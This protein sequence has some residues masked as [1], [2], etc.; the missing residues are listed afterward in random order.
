MTGSPR[1]SWDATASFSGYLYQADIALLVTLEKIKDINLDVSI[2]DKMAEIAK[3]S[4]E[5]E[6]EEDFT[7]KHISWKKESYQVKETKDTKPSE[8]TIA[9]VKL[10][11]KFTGS[12]H[13]NFLIAKNAIS[14][15]DRL[16]LFDW[17]YAYN[18]LTSNLEKLRYLVTTNLLW[19]KMSFISKD[20]ISFLPSETKDS[21]YEYIKTK[22]EEFL[23]ETNFSFNSYWEW[24]NI[25][26]SIRVSLWIIKSWIAN[27]DNYLKFLESKIKRNIQENKWKEIWDRIWIGLL[28]ISNDI[29]NTDINS[30]RP[31]DYR[32][33]FYCF[34]IKTFLCEL[35]KYH[36]DKDNFSIGKIREIC[37]EEWADKY[38][39]F[40]SMI[41]D[42]IGI[43][44][45]NHYKTTSLIKHTIW[46]KEVNNIE[47]ISNFRD[48][49][50]FIEKLTLLSPKIQTKIT[51][52]IYYF[53]A[54][55]HP[56]NHGLI[57][58]FFGWSDLYLEV[59][60]HDKKWII[61]WLS[62]IA[63][64][65]NFLK[66]DIFYRYEKDYIWILGIEDKTI[67]EVLGTLF[68]NPERRWLDSL[69]DAG[70]IHSVCDIFKNEFNITKI[71]KTW[72]F[73]WIYCMKSDSHKFM[74]KLP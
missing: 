54:K 20:E 57:D 17:I 3:W 28:E 69:E 51:F 64:L 12:E 68:N 30:L 61:T 53:Y 49:N 43:I 2:I 35:E 55:S 33:M 66:S 8:Y 48:L 71:K 70:W 21:I 29:Q 44:F 27:S 4:L 36:I 13:K 38:T 14:F 47:D 16:E 46:S 74:H 59:R 1:S 73:W 67:D 22:T 62:G 11:E 25:H 41:Q 24:E 60:Q 72:I 5:V 6:G 15:T 63:D 19:D 65:R 9:M 32:E 18:W 39:N 58:D 23:N 26:N 31:E 7:L 50:D 40:V 37:I 42:S 52:L 45:S 34:F 10:Y 56:I